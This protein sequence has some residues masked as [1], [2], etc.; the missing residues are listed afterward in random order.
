MT[1]HNQHYLELNPDNKEPSTWVIWAGAALTLAGV[2]IVI[3]LSVLWGA[4]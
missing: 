4:A 2:Y 1:K 3:L